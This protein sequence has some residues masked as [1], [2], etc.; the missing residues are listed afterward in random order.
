MAGEDQQSYLARNNVQVGRALGLLALAVSIALGAGLMLGT[1]TRGTSAILTVVTIAGGCFT[2]L[3][4]SIGALLEAA[5]PPEQWRAEEEE[6][7]AEIGLEPLP[8]DGSA[9]PGVRSPGRAAALASL[10][11][12]VGLALSVGPSIF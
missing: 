1:G 7:R 2:L 8:A 3:L 9:A 12:L 10:S 4:L 6:W 5:V 11:I